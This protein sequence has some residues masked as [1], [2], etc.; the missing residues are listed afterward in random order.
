MTNFFGLIDLWLRYRFQTI[1]IV[2]FLLWTPLLVIETLQ[3]QHSCYPMI[4]WSGTL[5]VECQP[6]ALQ[7]NSSSSKK[8]EIQRDR[9][10]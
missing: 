5:P 7:L 8:P 9:T 4:H 10:V 3:I 1:L 6:K 2:C